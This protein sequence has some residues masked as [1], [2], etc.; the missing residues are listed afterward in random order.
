MNRPY[1]THL[2]ANDKAHLKMAYVHLH[3][4]INELAQVFDKDNVITHMCRQ[5]GAME[6]TLWEYV[7]RRDKK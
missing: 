2:A 1:N 6:D 3:D 5:L 7:P 4:T